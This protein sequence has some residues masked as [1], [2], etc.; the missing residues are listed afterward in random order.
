M[1]STVQN[2]TGKVD[3]RSVPWSGMDSKDTMQW[4][5]PSEGKFLIHLAS[6]CQSLFLTV[7]GVL[8]WA[9]FLGL[10]PWGSLKRGSW[11]SDSQ[12]SPIIVLSLTLLKPRGV[13]VDSVWLKLVLQLGSNGESTLFSACGE[14]TFCMR[15]PSLSA[16]P[17]EGC[18]G[19]QFCVQFT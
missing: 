17:M 8:F 1:G 2:L 11:L 12:A 4:P 7:L 10:D 15:D 13:N 18:N 14:L 16:L 9:S 5:W 6:E 3:R 19:L